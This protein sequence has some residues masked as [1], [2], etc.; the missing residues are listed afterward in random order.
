MSKLVKGKDLTPAQVSQVKAAFLYRLT[1]ENGY[2]KRNPVGATVPAI[3]DG[4][5]LE[6]HAFFIR[7]DGNL[8]SKPAFC[9][10]AYMADEEN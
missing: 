7:K 4:E 10:P 9:E 8:A 3:T 2:P 5:W 1:V 6:K